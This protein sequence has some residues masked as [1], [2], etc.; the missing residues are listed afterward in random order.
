MECPSSEQIPNNTH[1]FVCQMVPF[2]SIVKFNPSSKSKLC[3]ASDSFI[4]SSNSQNLTV[5]K[6]KRTI[7][8]NYR[9]MFLR[10]QSRASLDGGKSHKFLQ[11]RSKHID[12]QNSSPTTPTLPH[13]WSNCSIVATNVRCN[14]SIISEGVWHPFRSFEKACFRIHSTTKL[15]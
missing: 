8:L 2:P 11:V 1:F 4:L 15:K 7:H 6:E 14:H 3:T 9:N 10:K 13:S 5:K 12:I